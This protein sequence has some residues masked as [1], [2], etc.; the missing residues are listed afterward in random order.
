MPRE[1]KTQGKGRKITGR[2]RPSSQWRIFRLS[3]KASL[4]AAGRKYSTAGRSREQ[5]PF[6]NGDMRRP[7]SG[8]YGTGSSRGRREPPGGPMQER[9]Q[10]AGPAARQREDGFSMEEGR[11]RLFSEPRRD[12][13]GP[14]HAG[15]PMSSE[16]R[17]ERE[18]RPSGQARQAEACEVAGDGEEKR[19]E[20]F[21]NGRH[22]P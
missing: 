11:S 12:A 10:K 17:S 7:G 18:L 15:R 4:A 9:R 19:G 5:L 16:G 21:R 13:E 22:L 20:G 3:S 1:G 14:A 6:G 8:A 2:K